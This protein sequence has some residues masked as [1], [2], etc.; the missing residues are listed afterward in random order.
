M[1]T[2]ILPN[3]NAAM[4]G[5]LGQLPSIPAVP[6]TAT[7]TRIAALQAKVQ[8]YKTAKGKMDEMKGNPQKFCQSTSNA[9]PA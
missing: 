9:C 7:M 1:S 5:A 2:S 3:I 8:L 4:N 6:S